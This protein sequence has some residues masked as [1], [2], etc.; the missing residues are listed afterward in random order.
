M[1]MGSTQA[2][3]AKGATGRAGKAAFGGGR[4]RA[5]LARRAFVPGKPGGR[6][7]PLYVLVGLTL[8]GAAVVLLLV[9]RARRGG[10][11]SEDTAPSASPSASGPSNPEDA[12]GQRAEGAR[13]SRAPVP[14]EASRS[15]RDASGE[16]GMEDRIRARVGQD[17]RTKDL[18]PPSIKVEDGM[19]WIE[20]RVPTP[21]AREALTEVVGDIEGVNIVVNRV[22]V[23]TP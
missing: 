19:V 23:D 17:P 1:V 3:L 15:R 21:E 14:D 8:G 5:G 6:R 4:S 13:A 10:P 18:P 9:R 11:Q 22:L 20:G 7:Y 2:R 12:A 16:G